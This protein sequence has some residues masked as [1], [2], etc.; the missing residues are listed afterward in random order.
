MP[1]RMRERDII[2]PLPRTRSRGKTTGLRGST[3]GIAGL[4]SPTRP[5]LKHDAF[6][7][8]GFRKA[9]GIV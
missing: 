1:Y 6:N 8:R 3:V 4:K 7:G 9:I 2:S 5:Y